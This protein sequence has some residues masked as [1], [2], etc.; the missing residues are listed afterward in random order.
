MLKQVL[1]LF[2]FFSMACS[3]TNGQSFVE[4]DSL[5]KIVGLS[6]NQARVYK[7]VN[8][9]EDHFKGLPLKSLDSASLATGKVLAKYGVDNRAAYEYLINS[10]CQWRLLHYTKAENNLIKAINYVEKKEDHYFLYILLNYL[11][12]SQTEDG[13]ATGA[14]S[15]YRAAKMEAGKLDD[16]YMLL[17]VNIN[18]SDVYY[19]NNYYIQALDYLNE[20]GSI[21]SRFGKTN[22]KIEKNAARLEIVINYNKAE[23]FFLT[24][25]PDSLKVYNRKLLKA[26]YN[27]YKLYTYQKRST[28]YLDLLNHNYKKAIELIN[29]MR[30]NATYKFDNRDNICLADAYFKNG[31]TDSAIYLISQLLKDPS[32]TNHPEVSFHL[33]DVLGQIAEKNN[34][35]KNAAL[36]FKLALRKAEE[37][38]ARLTQVGNVSSLIKIDDIENA[39]NQKNEVFQRERIWLIFAVFA[40]LFTIVIIAIIYRNVK[41]KRH[42]ENLLFTAKKE[43]LAFINSHEVRKHLTNI[44]GLVDM[45][46]NSN[47]KEIEYRE[48]E[49]Y[50]FE[51]AEHL[52]AA[53]KNI[54]A[55]LDD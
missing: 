14:I 35:Y 30:R 50:L 27:Y 48:A 44:L 37:Y 53:I 23:I 20:A 45:I 1:I 24:R 18:I 52:D 6:D 25:N 40:A 17:I 47:N 7:L 51:S 16:G 55:K 15:S 28:Y 46:R 4:T 5:E 3:S 2:L 12:F 41:Q 26:T 49:G 34:D 38:N 33:Y 9:F 39:Y 32:E 11:A 21:I 22:K 42:Y 29:R 36:N 10:F 54:S 31:Q 19:K 13:N 43:E 8:Y